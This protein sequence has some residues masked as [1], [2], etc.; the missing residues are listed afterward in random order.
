MKNRNLTKQRDIKNAMV[1]VH[2]DLKNKIAFW[3][4]FDDGEDPAH[5]RPI[6]EHIFKIHP[7]FVEAYTDAIIYGQGYYLDSRGRPVSLSL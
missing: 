3:E 2:F 4:V 7:T 5:V 6:M 1:C